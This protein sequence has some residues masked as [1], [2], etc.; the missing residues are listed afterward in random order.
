MKKAQ[1]QTNLIISEHVSVTISQI[2]QDAYGKQ[3]VNRTYWSNGK[4][5]H[6]LDGDSNNLM[7]KGSKASEKGVHHGSEKER[8]HS[9]RFTQLTLFP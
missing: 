7:V 9:K 5:I 3:T 8:K 4:K 1:S 6:Q 2:N